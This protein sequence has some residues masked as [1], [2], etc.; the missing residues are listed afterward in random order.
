[1]LAS[2]LE[3]A[4]EAAERLADQLERIDKATRGSR[5]EITTLGTEGV[6]LTPEARARF[7]A[8]RDRRNRFL[9]SGGTLEAVAP[10]SQRMPLAMP[11]WLEQTFRSLRDQVR[12]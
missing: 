8:A 4:A 1:A 11:S 3:D 9:A 7:D 2:P 5:I 6:Q 10:R 12:G